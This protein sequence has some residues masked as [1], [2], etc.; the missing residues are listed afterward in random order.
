MGASPW[1][2]VRKEFLKRRKDLL[3]NFNG[4]LL[5]MGGEISVQSKDSSN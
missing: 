4:F 5:K 3:K 1:N 2:T